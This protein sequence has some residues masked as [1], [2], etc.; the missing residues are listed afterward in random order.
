MPKKSS[1]PNRGF[2][3]ADQPSS[4]NSTAK[5]GE[6]VG[7]WRARKAGKQLD[8]AVDA[9]GPASSRLRTALD[10]QAQRLAAHLGLSLRSVALDG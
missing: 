2:Q 9:F 1:K 4:V 8:L 7:T 10:E 3:V 6:V 5:Y